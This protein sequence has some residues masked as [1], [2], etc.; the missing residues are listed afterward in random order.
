[1]DREV[2]KVGAE[3]GRRCDR[4]QDWRC[5]GGVQL[6]FGTA[7]AAVEVTVFRRPF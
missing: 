2:I 5:G 3:A 6:F 4:L 1:V 7:A